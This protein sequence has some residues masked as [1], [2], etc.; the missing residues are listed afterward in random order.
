MNND[1]FQGS[2]LDLDLVD[3]NPDPHPPW[4]RRIYKK[5]DLWKAFDLPSRESCKGS[6]LQ[7][8]AQFYPGMTSI[9]EFDFSTLN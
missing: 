2:D 9:N 7:A 4:F 5:S 6:R 8:T 1:F 3:L